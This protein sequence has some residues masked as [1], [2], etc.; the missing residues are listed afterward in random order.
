MDD[1]GA[2]LSTR[3]YLHTSQHNCIHSTLFL[4]FLK[5]GLIGE[6]LFESTGSFFGPKYSS[7]VLVG[8]SYLASDVL[9]WALN[10]IRPPRPKV[11]ALM[12]VHAHGMDLALF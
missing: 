2:R 10:A 12:Y 1:N 3:N 11:H 7:D 6:K 4:F 8:L 9:S 5:T